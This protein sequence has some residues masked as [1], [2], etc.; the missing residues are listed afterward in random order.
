M[1]ATDTPTSPTTRRATSLRRRVRTLFA[2]SIAV[3]VLAVALG[4]IGFAQ[5]LDSRE[6]LVDRI[7][8]ASVRT[9]GVFSNTIDRLR[10]SQTKRRVSGA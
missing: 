5:L 1:S 7:D 4:A 2:V 3:A 8:P 10:S 6:E 9:P